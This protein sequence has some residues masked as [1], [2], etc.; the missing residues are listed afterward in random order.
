ML[1]ARFFSLLV[2]TQQPPGKSNFY[3][4]YCAVAQIIFNWQIVKYFRQEDLEEIREKMRYQTDLLVVGYADDYLRMGKSKKRME[5]VTQSM[6]DRCILE[7]IGDFLAGVLISPK[8]V[9]MANDFRRE[10]YGRRRHNSTTSSVDSESSAAKRS[11]PGMFMCKTTVNDNI[12]RKMLTFWCRAVAPV[13]SYFILF[14]N[15]I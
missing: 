12:I 7:E 13:K 9:V 1:D 11:R 10:I 5:G 2:K 6:V 3:Y 15:L 8:P 4:F 14:N